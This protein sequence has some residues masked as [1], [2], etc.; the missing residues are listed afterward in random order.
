MMPAPC[1][2]AFVQ[3]YCMVP[4]S[5]DKG[6]VCWTQHLSLKAGIKRG[7]GL[8]SHYIACRAGGMAFS[9]IITPTGVT[10]SVSG[11]DSSALTGSH[12]ERTDGDVQSAHTPRQHY[13]FTALPSHLST[14]GESAAAFDTPAQGTPDGQ[15]E[16][17]SPG[18]GQLKIEPA[19]DL[20]GCALLSFQGAADSL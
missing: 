7:D 16:G 20:H 4:T 5:A 6:R 11:D 13:A 2:E 12:P 17:P 14:G 8:L 3:R 9:G 18:N 10:P 1:A 19:A 15:P